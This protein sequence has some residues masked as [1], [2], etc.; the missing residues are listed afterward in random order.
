MHRIFDFAKKQSMFPHSLK[1]KL[2]LAVLLLLGLFIAIF[3]MNNIILNSIVIKNTN[4]SVLNSINQANLSLSYVLEQAKEQ[5]YQLSTQI[6]ERDDIERLLTQE[7]PNLTRYQEYNMTEQYISE[8][9]K[10]VLTTKMESIYVYSPLRSKLLT[11]NNGIFD[12]DGISGYKWLTQALSISSDDALKW[13]GNCPY[14]NEQQRNPQSSIVSLI[15]RAHIINRAMKG[16]VFFGL[17]FNEATIYSIF[18]D[19][20][21][22]PNTLVYLTDQNGTVISSRD[23]KLIGTSLSQAQKASVFSGNSNGI[24]RIAVGGDY[25]QRIIVDNTIT[26]WK[27]VVLIPEKELLAKRR[28]FWLFV[29]LSLSLVS[30]GFSFIAYRTIVKFVDRPVMKLVNFMKVVEKGN[31]KVNIREERKDEFGALY[32]GFNEMVGKIDVLIRELYQE[33]LLKRDIELKYLQKL[34]NPH[35]LY[36]TLDTIRWL[37]EENRLSDV[38]SLTLVLSNLYRATFN[39]GQDFVTLNASIL[40]IEN[41]L[42][43]HKARYG[44]LFSY[45]IDVKEELKNYLILNLILQPLVENSLLHGIQKRESGGGLVKISARMRDNLIFIRVFDNG[46]GMRKDKLKIIKANMKAD[47]KTNDS[48]L[49]IV[50]QRI[51]LFYGDRYGLCI[52]SSFKRGTCFSFSFPVFEHIPGQDPL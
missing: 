20:R 21:I 33:K 38:S 36:N 35:F 42:Y 9:T 5:A 37:A 19:I 14:L 8:L 11:S 41:Y 4:Q 34:I 50:Y 6:T 32:T 47:R 1:T 24:E 17:N 2:I 27:I 51:K 46:I 25:F 43:I 29:V 16:E 12:Y 52:K 7:S 48:G 22:S 3:M 28:G 40:S 10:I 13:V 26:N 39:S 23:K 44:E 45:V 49:K 18:R 15:C 31:F 30:V